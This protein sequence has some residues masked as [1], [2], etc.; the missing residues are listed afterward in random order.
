MHA[1]PKTG[2]ATPLVLSFLLLGIMV[3]AVACSGPIC[4]RHLYIFRE[5]PEKSPVAIT[6]LVITDPNLAAALVPEASARLHQGLP[7][8]PEQLVHE[9]EAYR[10]SLTQVD[11]RPVYQ[12]LCLDTL[13]TDVCEVRAGSRRLSVDVLLFGPWGRRTQR[14]QLPVDLQAATV[15]FLKVAGS[16]GDEGRVQVLAERLAPYTPEFRQRLLD[17]ERSHAPGRTLD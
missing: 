7:W 4:K 14:E 2:N 16:G 8:A 15:Y 12:G 3:F 17:Y 10:L 6:A 5:A 11:G 13:I 9:T 1:R